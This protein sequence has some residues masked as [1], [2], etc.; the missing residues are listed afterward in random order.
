MKGL[1]TKDFLVLKKQYM[2]GL[3]TFILAIVSLFLFRQIGIFIGMTIFTLTMSFVML[4]SMTQD[5][6]NHGWEYLFTLPIKRS[7]YVN[8]KYGLF[9]FIIADATIIMYVITLL[10]NKMMNWHLN[11]K[12][13]FSRVYLVAIL[14]VAFIGI[15]IFCQMKYGPDIIQT[16]MS[17]VG[18]VVAVVVGAIYAAVKYTDWGKKTFNHVYQ[19]FIDHGSFMF[20]FWL[21]IIVLVILAI[22]IYQSKRVIKNKEL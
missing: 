4:N 5:Q 11:Y 1:L 19:Y 20:L 16:L 18:A 2:A 6:K 22:S 3:L 7:D 17:M 8:E 13:I 15:L 9:M 10:T 21:T 14:T 12:G